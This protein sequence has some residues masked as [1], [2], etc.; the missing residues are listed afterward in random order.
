MHGILGVYENWA[1][2]G[3]RRRYQEAFFLA[4]LLLMTLLGRSLQFLV[5]LWGDTALVCLLVGTLKYATGKILLHRNLATAPGRMKI[6]VTQLI[7][8]NLLSL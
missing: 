1:G 4:A 2:W 7:G 3:R 6:A 8:D 5:A